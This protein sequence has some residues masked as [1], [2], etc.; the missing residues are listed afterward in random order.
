M[1]EGWANAP[2]VAVDLEDSTLTTIVET[3]INLTDGLTTDNYGNTYFS[4]WATNKTYRY[5]ETFTNPPEVV[6]SGHNGPA[7]IFCNKLQNILAVPNFNSNSVDF[8]PVPF[9]DQKE[10]NVNEVKIIRLFP[11]PFTD[12]V[13]F[14][15]YLPENALTKIFVY[16][17]LGNRIAEL[18]NEELI[19]GEYSISWNGRGGDDK[20]TAQGIYFIFFSIEDQS[21]TFKVI[22]H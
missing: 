8:I 2:I 14:D 16:D 6:S 15:F 17:I 11:N 9:T 18:I 22:K 19:R 21:K 13:H 12:Y 1:N 5:D 10:I 3:N 4:S 20:E 7:D